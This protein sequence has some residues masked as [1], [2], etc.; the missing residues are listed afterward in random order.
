MNI[1]TFPNGLEIDNSLT[2]LKDS[3]KVCNIWT[4]LFSW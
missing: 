1:E 3:K 2:K 4:G